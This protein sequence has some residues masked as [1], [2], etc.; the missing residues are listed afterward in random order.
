MASI[1]NVDAI[2]NVAGT[3]AL[4]IDSGGVVSSTAVLSVMYNSSSV[5][6]PD[7][8]D[9]VIP[10]QTSAVDTHNLY[11]A[12][13][14]RLLITSAFNGSYFIIS[15]SVMVTASDGDNMQGHLSKNGARLQSDRKFYNG[16]EG[17]S[18]SMH[19]VWMGQVSTNDYFGL[20]GFCDK[21]SG[22]SSSAVGLNNT[23]LYAAKLF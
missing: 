19:G 13:N 8:S 11:D 7:N 15:W 17:E 10:L 2:N 14:D 16:G 21:A 23:F 6:I 22:T 9:T 20:I 3:S 1:L 18:I 5:T 4:T 12:T